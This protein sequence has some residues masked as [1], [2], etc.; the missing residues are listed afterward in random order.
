[1]QP[2]W[3]HAVP[4]WVPHRNA[5]KFRVRFAR[6]CV[7]VGVPALMGAR[8][9]RRAGRGRGW[10][11]RPGPSSVRSGASLFPESGAGFL[12]RRPYHPYRPYRPYRRRRQHRWLVAAVRRAGAGRIDGSA[13]LLGRRRCAIAAVT[14]LGPDRSGG[15]AMRVTTT[16]CPV[17]PVRARPLPGRPRPAS[18]PAPLRGVVCALSAAETAR[19]LPKLNGIGPGHLL[20]RLRRASGDAAHPH[21][22]TAWGWGGAGGRPRRC[23]A[24]GWRGAGCGMREGR[25]SRWHGVGVGREPGSGGGGGGRPHCGTAWVYGH[26]LRDGVGPVQPGL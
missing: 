5:V 22:G 10:P 20:R 7:R 19:R 21:D 8:W 18:Q 23:E 1:V 14:S 12:A 25:A 6:R 11:A 15:P 24:C 13:L 9:L 16:L 26:L 17:R 2:G 3:P 4:E